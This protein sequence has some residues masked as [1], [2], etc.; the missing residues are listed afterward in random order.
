MIFPSFIN[1]TTYR[2]TFFTAKLFEVPKV[3]FW[4]HN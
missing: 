3:F 1:Q 4:T 2:E